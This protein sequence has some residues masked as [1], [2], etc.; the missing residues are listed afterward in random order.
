MLDGMDEKP[1][2]LTDRE[3]EDARI[4]AARKYRAARA[5]ELRAKKR[6][7]RQIDKAHPDPDQEAPELPEP[8]AWV[9]ANLHRI[10]DAHDSKT[11]S[12]GFG[13]EAAPSIYAW[14]M[15]MVA[16]DHRKD[17]M[18]KIMTELLSIRKE[19]DKHRRE[20]EV[21]KERRKVQLMDPSQFDGVQQ[22]DA[23]PDEGEIEVNQIL[24]RYT[25]Q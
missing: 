7:Q 21:L 20:M 6:M 5:N 19:E 12:T 2:D 14:N 15:L 1:D 9:W 8:L 18:T 17:F 10:P 4:E 23:T 16:A 11:W 25:G 22:P 13:P 3:Y 24:E